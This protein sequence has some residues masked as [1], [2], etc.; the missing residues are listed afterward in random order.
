[1]PHRW[2]RP[3]TAITIH[4][5]PIQPSSFTIHHTQPSPFTFHQSSLHHSPFTKHSHHHSPFTNPAF[6]IYRLLSDCTSKGQRILFLFLYV[7]VGFQLLHGKLS[8]IL[9]S[10]PSRPQVDVFITLCTQYSYI[11]LYVYVIIKQH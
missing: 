3:N 7:L 10:S 11:Q 4:H 2:L 6:T 1:M 8:F 9:I 5:S